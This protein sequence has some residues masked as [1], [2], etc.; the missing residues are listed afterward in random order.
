MT[1]PI[2][3][4]L[5]R[6]NTQVTILGA[7]PAGLLLAEILHRAGIASIVLERQDR[8]HVLSRIRAGVLE[9]TTVDVLRANGLAERLDREGHRH[10]GMRIVWA[11][12]ESFFIDIHQHLGLQFAT[13]GQTQIQEDLFAAA[14]RRGATVLTGVEDVRL[15]GLDSTRPQVRLRHRGEEVL[16]DCDFVAGCDGFHGVSR[17]SI[18]PGVLREFEKVYPFGW[19]GV[20]ARTPPLPDITYANHPRGFAL[21]SARNPTL[22]RWYLQVPLD[23]RIEDWPDERFWPELMTRFPPELADRIAPAAS[24]E[25]SIAPLRSYVCEPMRHGRLFLA[26]DAAHIVPPTGA[27]GLNLAVSDVFYLGRAIAS[28][29]A[30]GSEAPLDGYGAT[31]LRRVWSAVRVSWYLTNLLHRYPDASEFDQRLQEAELDTLKRSPA[32]QAALAR[33]Y[34]GL[35]L[36]PA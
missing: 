5:I 10:D 2:L 17:K 13:Y 6:M 19:L 8:A 21:G 25:K 23:T 35:P 16:I 20:L 9:P 34:A 4:I 31:A 11:G 18:P 1:V 29:Y 36:E 32:A 28:F 24:I 22:S 12:R 26:G 33:E 3:W 7:G 30:E 15:S 14:D 27:K